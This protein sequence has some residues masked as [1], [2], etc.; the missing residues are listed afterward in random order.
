MASET[1]KPT[2]FLRKASG[3]AREWSMF[4]V[5]AFQS[6]L[7]PFMLAAY[8]F[9]LGYLWTPIGNLVIAVIILAVFATFEVGTYAMMVPIMPKV[10]GDYIWQSRILHPFIGFVLIFVGWAIVLQ[11][12]VPIIDVIYIEQSFAPL[13]AIAGNLN[14]AFWLTSND[15][16][17]VTSVI[18]TV[19]FII[20][21]ALGMKFFATTLKVLFWIALAG[22][23]MVLVIFAVTSQATFIAGYN[24]FF[25]NTFGYAGANAFNDT[26]KTAQNLTLIPSN[27]PNS[28]PWDVRTS[29]P[30]VPLVTFYGVYAIWGAPMYGEV[31]GAESI[32]KTFWSMQ[33]AN[34]PMQ[35][36]NVAYLLL[37]WNVVGFRFFNASGALYWS[38]LPQGATLQPLLPFPGWWVYFMLGSNSF[39]FILTAFILI[40]NGLMLAV[41]S[42]GENFLL[43]SRMV[44][45]MSFDRMLPAVLAQLHTRRR[46]PGWTYL[47]I[48]IVTVIL[49]WLYAYNIFNWRV[50]TLDGTVVLAVGFAATA[51]AAALLPFRKKELFKNSPASKYMVGKVPLLTICGVIWF[52]FSLWFMWYW[53][54]DPLYGVNVPTSAAFLGVCYVATA[55]FFVVYRW[56]R[57]RQGIDVDMIFREI[58]GE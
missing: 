43:I 25:K 50:I 48:T 26:I 13:A 49:S 41:I 18:S 17:F 54:I 21:C 37:L 44:F 11:M 28:A 38:G 55:V 16:I 29:L 35:I 1:E 57:K 20:I 15:G 9:T 3:L 34:W 23:V 53:I 47:Y 2:L 30:L 27:T 40:G 45:A 52:V 8:Y 32:K 6:W 42:G 5:F 36:L 31:K 12:W 24:A 14:L 46:I 7:Q 39:S 10:G 4:D 33:A 58:P 22:L 51:L 19:A 56:Y